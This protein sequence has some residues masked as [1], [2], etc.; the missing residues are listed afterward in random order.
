MASLARARTRIALAK[1][2]SE[3]SRLNVF[4]QQVVNSLEKELDLAKQI[5]DAR[6]EKAS[7]A[8]RCLLKVKGGWFRIFRVNVRR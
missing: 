4:S 1:L 6:L 3:L 2:G 5:Q 7:F 8:K